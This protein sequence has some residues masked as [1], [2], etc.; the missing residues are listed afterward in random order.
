MSHHIKISAFLI[1]FALMFQH[2]CS[3]QTPAVCKKFLKIGISLPLTA[4]AISSGEAV[5]N[6]IMLADEKYDSGKC[7]EF[8]FE[9]DQTLAKNTLSIVRKF[10]D[11][12]HVDGLIVYGTPT[13]I[14]VGD[15]IEKNRVPMI[16]LS[17]LGKVVENK[18]YAMKHWCT[19]ERLDAAVKRE[20]G[21]RGYKSVAIV[22]TQNDAMFGLRDL[23]K[24]NKPA[25]IVLDEDYVRE[26][27]DFRSTIMRMIAK[28]ADAVYVLLYPPQTGIF[29]KQLREQGFKGDAFGVHNIEDPEE[30]KVS[31]GSML[32]MW[33]ANGDE[34][35]GENYRED[36]LRR[37]GIE[38][39]LGGASGF[40]SAKMFIEASQQGGDVN[41]Y[42][43]TL[44]DFH[45]AFGVYSA[46]RGNDFDFDAVIKVVEKE[47]FIKF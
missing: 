5:K 16:A 23:F 10:I 42:L 17:I 26:G 14:A 40:D 6:S 18:K 39:S 47:G 37:F 43:H 29:M 38:T 21:K 4:G 15:I 11:I 25:D 33:F 24:E 46:T 7:V 34:T 27:S 9:D 19:A 12:D 32:G 8:L 2:T 45:G 30:V 13:S 35:A 41:M 44:K 28:K 1:G 3:A 36:Y 22:S 20:I 31:V